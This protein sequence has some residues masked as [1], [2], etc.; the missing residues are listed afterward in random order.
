MTIETPPTPTTSKPDNISRLIGLLAI[1]APTF[2]L[3]GNSF[4]EGLLASFGIT[5]SLFPLSVQ[6]TYLN[7]FYGVGMILFSATKAL[8]EFIADLSPFGI[9]F[10]FFISVFVVYLY[11]K[12]KNTILDSTIAKTI[13]TKLKS[14]WKYLHWDNNHFSKALTVTAL[15][16][17]LGALV[18]YTLLCA[19]ILWLCLPTAA[20]IVGK[21]LNADSL[22]EFRTGGCQFDQKTGWS[23]CHTLKS[24]DGKVIHEG[25][26]TAQNSSRVAFFT[27]EGSNIFI[28]PKDAILSRQWQAIDKDH[29][30]KNQPAQ[31]AK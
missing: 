16:S 24:K 23:N 29:P 10:V 13:I 7:G 6:D 19:T 1:L 4:Y 12:F 27:K 15:I 11:S 8:I 17:Y 18:F 31:K 3:I 25:Y 14:C 9:L 21:N 26:L 22:V 5:N 28:I 20:Y 2:Y 30:K